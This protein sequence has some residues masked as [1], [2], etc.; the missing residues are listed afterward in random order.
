MARQLPS[1]TEVIP[2][3]QV[4]DLVFAQSVIG[5]I[6]GFTPC[7]DD[8]MFA[9]IWAPGVN[10]QHD[11]ARGLVIAMPMWER[12]GSIIYDLSL[13]QNNAAISTSGGSVGSYTNSVS[14]SIDDGY[15]TP[16]G[17]TFDNLASSISIG[18]TQTGF[19]R[20]RNVSVPQGATI[21]SATIQIVPSQLIADSL[22]LFLQGN[23]E[24]NAPPI[25]SVADGNSRVLTTATIT[26]NTGTWPYPNTP[27]SIDIT[28]IIQEIVNQGSWASGNALQIFISQILNGSSLLYSAASVSSYSGTPTNRP[29][30]LISYNSPISGGAWSLLETAN[31][32]A[33]FGWKYLNSNYAL[34]TKSSTF[35]VKNCLAS[36]TGGYAIS[37][38][39]RWEPTKVGSVNG[40]CILSTY[41][42]SLTSTPEN[43]G[44]RLYVTDDLDPNGV[45]TLNFRQ[46]M[47]D[48]SSIIDLSFISTGTVTDHNWFHVVVSIRTPLAPSTLLT[49]TMY[50]NGQL[51][52]SYTNA[53]VT[54][55]SAAGG[56]LVIGNYRYVDGTITSGN[57]YPAAIKDFRFYNRPLMAGEVFSLWRFPDELYRYPSLDRFFGFISQTLPTQTSVLEDRMFPDT[58]VPGINYFDIQADSIA[59]AMPMN[60]GGGSFL[61]DVSGNGNSGNAYYVFT[62]SLAPIKFA[63][64]S[65]GSTAFSDDGNL[66]S[67]YLNLLSSFPSYIA[68]NSNNKLLQSANEIHRLSLVG[69]YVGGTFTYTNN[70][71]VGDVT[72]TALAYN[73]SASDIR[74]A[75]IAIIVSGNTNDVSVSGTGPWYITWGGKFDHQYV[76]LGTVDG[77]NLFGNGQ[78]QVS[79]LQEGTTTNN[80]V[81]QIILYGTGGSYTL[82]LGSQTTPAI[83]WD[84]VASDLELDIVTY[85]NSTIYDCT[86]DGSGSPSDPFKVIVFGPPDTN[87]PIIIGNGSSQLLL[88]DYTTTEA[89]G[90]THLITNDTSDIAIYDVLFRPSL[91]EFINDT[92][93][94]TDLYVDDVATLSGI[95]VNWDDGVIWTQS[96]PSS[97]VYITDYFDSVTGNPVHAIINVDT[98]AVIF[99]DSSQQYH[100]GTFTDSSHAYYDSDHSF[101][102]T[103]IG[104]STINWSDGS[105]WTNGH[106]LLGGGG[107]SE[108]VVTGSSGGFS[109]AFSISIWFRNDLAAGGILASSYKPAVDEFYAVH[110]WQLSLDTTSGT[111]II[112]S[113]SFNNGSESFIATTPDFSSEYNYVNWHHVVAVTQIISDVWFVKI[114]LNGLLITSIDTAI[115]SDQVIDCG[116]DI[117]L[118][119]L[120]YADGGLGTAVQAASNQFAGPLKDFRIYNKDLTIGEVFNIYTFPD[121]LYKQSSLIPF[122]AGPT[123]AQF[124]LIPL[125]TP[126]LEDRMFSPHW[127]PGINYFSEQ[128]DSLIL[129]FPMWEKSSKTVYDVCGKNIGTIHGNGAIIAKTNNGGIFGEVYS[130][131]DTSSYITIPGGSK[132]NWSV[133][134][135]SDTISPAGTDVNRPILATADDGYGDY[136]TGSTFNNSSSTINLDQ[137]G[138]PSTGNWG[139]LRFTNITVTSGTIVAATLTI[140]PA[141]AVT[142]NK[143]NINGE[144]ATNATQ[145]TSASDF[146]SRA[147]TSHGDTHDTTGWTNGSDFT[148]SV[149][150]VVQ[151]I[152]NQGGWASGNALQL[153]IQALDGSDQPFAGNVLI[154]GDDGS[155]PAGRATL[156]IKYGSDALM[157]ANI[158][159]GN[160]VFMCL[161]SYNTASDTGTDFTISDTLSNT[162]TALNTFTTFGSK[163]ATKTFYCLSC[164]GGTTAITGAS[165]GVGSGT[166]TMSMTLLE[167]SGISAIDGTTINTGTTSASGNTTVSSGSCTVS[168]VNTLLFSFLGLDGLGILNYI[169]GNDFV[170]DL[171]V[172]GTVT[173]LVSS[174]EHKNVSSSAS[175][176]SGSVFVQSSNFGS[177][178][179]WVTSQNLIGYAV[180]AATLVPTI[181][182]GNYDFA[183][184]RFS[185]GFT[186]SFWFTGPDP[187]DINPS[188][189]V[190]TIPGN[191]SLISDTPTGWQIYTTISGG[192]AYLTA[193]FSSINSGIIFGP[194][195]ASTLIDVQN[196]HNV[197]YYAAVVV[198]SY[199]GSWQAGIYINGQNSG[200]F[201]L[202]VYTFV[203]GTD[204]ILGGIKNDDGTINTSQT[205][206][207]ELKDFRLYGKPLT[208]GEI[209]NI[210][211][212]PDELYRQPSLIPWYSLINIATGTGG[213]RIG[214]VATVIKICI[215]TGTGGLRIGG[216]AAAIEVFIYTGTGGLR[217]GSVP[218]F[219]SFITATQP[220][221]WYRLNDASGTTAVN[222]GILSSMDGTYHGG[223]VLHQPSLILSDVADYSVQLNGATGY[224]SVPTNSVINNSSP[225]YT[226]TIM[227]WFQAS[228]NTIARQSLYA[229]GDVNRGFGIYL[230]SNVITVIV[231]NKV[232]DGFTSAWGV[233]Y[234]FSGAIT[235]H[236]RHHVALGFNGLGA[237]I[238]YLDGQI[239]GTSF[240]GFSAVGLHASIMIGANI[241][242]TSYHDGSNSGANNYYNNLLDEVIVYGQ[243]L[244]PDEVYIN[245]RVSIPVAYALFNFIHTATGGLRIGGMSIPRYYYS[246]T[247][248]LRIGGAAS[249]ANKSWTGTGGLRIGG[250]AVSSIIANYIIYNASGGLRIGG[251]ASNNPT[252]SG[253]GGLKL[254]GSGTI[255]SHLDIDQ[256]F[257]WNINS[258][259]KINNDF[260]WNLSKGLLTFY[261]I[262]TLC[263]QQTCPPLSTNDSCLKTQIITIAARSLNDVCSQLQSSGIT[264]GIAKIEQYSNPIF[265]SDFSSSN[266]INCNVLKDVTPQFESLTCFPLLSSSLNATVGGNV[267]VQENVFTYRASG[268]LFIGGIKYRSHGILHIGGSATVTMPGF[269]DTAICSAGGSCDISEQLSIFG[270]DA[271]SDKMSISTDVV[272]LA[273]SSKAV[274]VI[275]EISHNLLQVA[276][277]SNFLFKNKFT[278]PDVLNMT[279]SN[280][281]KLWSSSISFSGKSTTNSGIE[282]W[283]LL[284][285]FGCD[286][287][288]ADTYG[289]NLWTFRLFLNSKNT[290]GSRKSALYLSFNSES[291]TPF[292][293]TFSVNVSTKRSTPPSFF[294]VIFDD[295]GIFT[296]KIFSQNPVLIFSISPS[297]LAE[298][299]SESSFVIS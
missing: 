112:L 274:P 34:I 155:H 23:K 185:Y 49:G 33:P 150:G 73:A 22:R 226:R 233:N 147:L 59:L 80:E 237:M 205:F 79:V 71:G 203:D 108:R 162:W 122:F 60:E 199:N 247:G 92:Q 260:T 128:A 99:V 16:S 109:Q 211:S 139:F 44:W 208:S 200:F 236:S 132:V 65:Y 8:R 279:W 288:Q 287:T 40:G 253:S 56:Q 4:D 214:G 11:H 234:L 3:Y 246:G 153:F 286:N 282:S 191:A 277:L 78:V 193:S 32:G 35:S 136:Y 118:G 129:A 145:V 298:S 83:A 239:F 167:V 224:I 17:S 67:R 87:I 189:I 195:T 163:S 28:T 91:G 18:G 174:L 68:V 241:Q 64:W 232:A 188:V 225:W 141:S 45:R 272:N 266:D 142:P 179:V 204:L 127:A 217:I 285:D 198:K 110:G 131:T 41:E 126:C 268:G 70:F 220:L 61:N 152:I 244:S 102:A 170:T 140:R 116:Q 264:G 180:T 47:D 165:V 257:E 55:F 258:L 149:T 194:V 187:T 101:V 124:N 206:V 93:F 26:Y 255:Q 43:P 154:V 219:N 125:M 196:Y 177:D 212:M 192:A 181:A 54:D 209:F 235:P 245:Y 210:W 182:S 134:Q 31:N 72:T 89:P 186:I 107:L 69:T 229:E 76:P 293:L 96:A 283:H 197:F 74:A 231:W 215:Y 29:L 190:S 104:T 267:F 20:F 63:A 94:L 161:T 36:V 250:T 299:V 263:K 85:L 95:N 178:G 48:D 164:T 88:V 50:V 81:Q 42:P 119:N 278:L 159:S 256:G 21:V 27:I 121:V 201:S 289:N 173:T 230:F 144:L 213:L 156:D 82:T 157:S 111:A 12:A 13:N 249:Y 176:P 275:L 97:Q 133:V 138:S 75:I 262:T 25:A 123:V 14:N 2:H 38:W 100:L 24:L 135:Y 168:N 242:G 252:Y 105:H 143:I 280:L 130:N 151:E 98:N 6:P 9:D 113:L 169:S 158:T 254:G 228:D 269:I 295:E 84:T 30:I 284:F 39:F 46:M 223:F 184:S 265:S 270:F 261:Q 243:Y 117:T 271:V 296:D 183:I 160:A 175:M 106:R 292:D 15:W 58:W 281:N 273:C 5:S 297:I 166:T 19:L 222:S 218:S 120:R 238:G 114:Y 251:A 259:I 276:P 66:G 137:T 294:P 148:M 240:S 115:S 221:L 53:G 227:L 57:A 216:H 103:F 290:S 172:G 171:S 37:I 1:F 90:E 52:S 10:Y 248:G 86:V 146:R 291:I 77:T 51:V 207:G 62:S 7:I 202:P